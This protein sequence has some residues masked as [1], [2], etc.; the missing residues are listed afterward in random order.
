[1]GHLC[2]QHTLLTCIVTYANLHPFKHGRIQVFL[3]CHN[4]LHTDTHL[5]GPFIWNQSPLRVLIVRQ[6]QDSMAA[7]TTMQ[8]AC[9]AAACARHAAPFQ[10]GFC[11]MAKCCGHQSGS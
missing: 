8:G 1:M 11:I 4:M 9:E 7:G 10:A 3:P 6:F 2:V 5:S